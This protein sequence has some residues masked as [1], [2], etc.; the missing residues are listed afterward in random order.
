MVSFSVNWGTNKTDVAVGDNTFPNRTTRIALGPDGT[1]YV[2]Y[3]QRMGSIDNVFENAYFIVSRSDDC[4]HNWNTGVSITG[5]TNWVTGQNEVQTFFTV[6]FGNPSGNPNKKSTVVR[7]SDA[8][9][10]VGPNGLVGPSG[11]PI[12]PVYVVYVSKDTSGFG[13]IYVA[14]STDKGMTWCSTRVTN[15]M[16]NSAFAEIAVA[17]VANNDILGVL[18]LDYDD[19][20]PEATSQN[21][22]FFRYHLAIGTIAIGTSGTTCTSSWQDEKLQ[23]FDP[24]TLQ[25][26]ST[27]CIYNQ[28][29]TN[30]FYVGDFQGLTAAG[31]S[32]YGAFT[33]QSIGRATLQFDPIFFMRPASSSNAPPSVP[34]NLK[35]Q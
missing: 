9:I 10:A 8:W 23:S 2:V 20:S 22:T 3:K 35:V 26:V 24:S 21:T 11:R 31:N 33:G 15:G 30:C 29:P 17:N 13:Q 4:G 28:Q 19:T 12:Y 25:N 32:F 5:P 16:H 1:A 34:Q 7:S 6:F 27:D 14:R 18:Y